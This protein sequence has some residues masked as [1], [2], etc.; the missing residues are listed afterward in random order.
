MV[1][2]FELHIIK[3]GIITVVDIITEVEG[4]IA[5]EGTIGV[6]PD[7]DASF[8]FCHYRCLISCASCRG[9]AHGHQLASLADHMDSFNLELL[10]AC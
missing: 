5:V 4:I 8:S 1:A 6:T 9:H 3:V 2:A 7:G 10:L